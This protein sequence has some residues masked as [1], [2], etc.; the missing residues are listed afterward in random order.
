MNVNAPRQSMLRQTTLLVWITRTKRTKGI[1]EAEAEDDKVVIR[2]NLDVFPNEL[3]FKIFSELILWSPTLSYTE[4]AKQKT[5]LRE[6]STSWY[7]YIQAEPRFWVHALVG[8]TDDD[9]IETYAERSQGRNLN[10]CFQ[11]KYDKVPTTPIAD[12]SAAES[13]QGSELGSEETEDSAVDEERRINSSLDSYRSEWEKDNLSWGQNDSSDDDEGYCSSQGNWLLENV[14]EQVMDVDCYVERASTLIIDTDYSEAL[15]AMRKTSAQM[16]P[17]ALRRL[18][19]RLAYR[20]LDADEE[21]EDHPLDAIPWFTAG[22]W[23]EIEDLH[24]TNIALP[25]KS[26]YAPKLSTLHMFGTGNWALMDIDAYATVIENAPN[27]HHLTLAN[28]RCAYLTEES[29]PRNIHSASMQTFQLKQAGN[30]SMGILATRF[31][32]TQL[33]CM[34]VQVASIVDLEDLARTE[35]ILGRI[36]RLQIDGLGAKVFDCRA[37]YRA[38]VN[39]DEL[40]LNGSA[41]LFT[42]LMLES[43]RPDSGEGTSIM[44]NLTTLSVGK[45]PLRVVKEYIQMHD[46]QKI[47]TAIRIKRRGPSWGIFETW[48]HNFMW[49]ASRTH[50]LIIHEGT[51]MGDMEYENARDWSQESI[52]G[53]ESAR[54]IEVMQHS[55]DNLLEELIRIP[56][57]NKSSVGKSI[58]AG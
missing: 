30:A 58:R 47:F 53:K 28:M 14:P 35:N 54:A 33:E 27:L 42:D 36:K 10:I 48:K 43:E 18:C 24:I 21:L 51:F 39:V 7:R 5:I 11:W 55:G 32:F 41:Q 34:R 4:R 25:L 1:E 46:D 17:N 38:C 50:E 45:I 20:Q 26:M 6:A 31:R 19:I 3:L 9:W 44:P 13:E 49:I 15:V 40:I 37:A 56:P 57:R 22:V 12:D 52:Y 16:N 29:P 23:E 8:D 2:T